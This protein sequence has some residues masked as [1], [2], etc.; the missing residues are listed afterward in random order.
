MRSFFVL[1]WNGYREARRNRV[2]VVV[3]M[4]AL[5][6]LLSAAL[7]TDVTVYT[8]DRV[9]TDFGLGAMSMTL[10]LLAIFLSTSQL[11][12]EIERRTIFLVVSK[13][14]SRSQFLVARFAGNA[15]TLGAMLVLMSAFLSVQILLNHS[16][17][18]SA[19]L[20]AMGMLWVELV[21][22]SSV[23]FVMSSFSSQMVSAVVTTGVYFA[24]H[25]SADIYEQARK[26]KDPA[27]KVLG[28][29]VYYVLPNLER[30]N[31]RPRAA[32]AV[33]STPTEILSATAYGF[34]YAAVMI[35]I[36]CLLF[37]KR[38]FK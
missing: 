12:R 28:K 38:D 23:G 36:A 20:A 31:F 2:S 35:A 18:N 16:P 6:L 8:F 27:L 19:V 26:A 17:L 24:G 34:A 32:F 5:A 4:F 7:V 15:F 25:L 1:A 37:E 22:V 3:A 11:T 9:I 33:A 29:L 14:V 30:L 10:A 21:V 13:P